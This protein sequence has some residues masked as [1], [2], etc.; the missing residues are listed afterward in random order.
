M[1]TL[2]LAWQQFDGTPVVVA[3]NR[4]EALD[5]PAEPPDRFAEDPVVVAPRDTRAGGTWI[6]VNEYDLFVG[7]TNR[8]T[9]ADIAGDRS[10]GLLVADALRRESAETAISFVS[11]SCE[12]FEYSGFYLVV[13]DADD[14]FVCDWDGTLSIESLEPGCHVV[15]N[16]G[17]IDSPTVPSR[18]RDAGHRQLSSGRL[19][20]RAL[21]AEST[22]TL[23]PS[24]SD[25][26]TDWLD[27]AE[28]VLGDHEYG[29]CRHE[30]G[31]GTRSSSLVSLGAHREYRYADGPPCRTPFERVELESHL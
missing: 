14:A 29:V 27:R 31:F 2:A 3:A 22:D 10:R 1:C 25:A 8:W 23:N 18:R 19:V 15:T 13:A 30:N 21:C 5:R 26:V 20:R 17:H 4:D 24:P 16:V 6:G 9:D 28:S 12:Q 11:D 7:I